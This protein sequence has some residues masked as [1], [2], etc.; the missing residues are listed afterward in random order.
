MAT[1]IKTNKRTCEGRERIIKLSRAETVNLIKNLIDLLTDPVG[2]G[3]VNTV[4]NCE[5]PKEGTYR[6]YLSPS[7]R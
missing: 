2:G 1:Q 7:E 3:I 5:D 4:V 6:L